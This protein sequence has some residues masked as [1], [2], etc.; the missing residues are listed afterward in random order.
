MAAD[1]RVDEID[2]RGYRG[3]GRLVAGRRPSDRRRRGKVPSLPHLGFADAAEE[4]G[5]LGPKW[6][7]FDL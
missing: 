1:D 6:I 4:A 2:S 3:I 5:H 7:R